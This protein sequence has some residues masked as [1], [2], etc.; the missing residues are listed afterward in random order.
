MDWGAWWAAIHGVAKSQTRLKR[1]SSSS[2]SSSTSTVQ[3]DHT[4]GCCLHL[5]PKRSPSYLLS[6]WE[7][8]QDQQV[9]LTQHLSNCWPCTWD[10]AYEMLC[11]PFKKH[12]LGFLNPSGS[13]ECTAHWFLKPNVLGLY[14]PTTGPLV[15]RAWFGALM[16]HSSGVMSATVILLLFVSHHT[17]GCVH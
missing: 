12:R 6:L 11:V 7:A 4:N 10:S 13:L 5:S 16:P 15:C 2:S 17:S 3:W 9:G 1:L 8:L 14:F